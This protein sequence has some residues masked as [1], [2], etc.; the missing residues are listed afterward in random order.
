MS[1]FVLGNCIDVMARIPD[2]AIDFILTDPPY[3]VGFRD[4]QG[5]TIA[6]DKTDEWLQPAC[7]EMYRVLKKDALMVSFYGWN[8]VDRFMSAWKNAGFSVVGHLVFT[9]NYT[10]KAAYVGYRHECAY[11]LAKGRPRLPQNPLPDVLGWK[12]SGNRHHPTEKPVTSL[13]PLIES[14]THPNAIVLD[15]FAGSGSTCVAALQS[16]RRYIGIELL[17]QYHPCWLD[18]DDENLPVVLDAILNRGARFS[19]VEMYLV[20]D[21]IEHILS[22]GL[23]CDVLR[24]PDEPPRRWFD[25]GVL[26]EVVREARAEIRSM[27]DAL[28]KI[29]K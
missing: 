17:E 20:S 1:R 11:I 5:R 14:F 25:R 26:R 10:S 23:A 2:N 13:Q 16:G 4:R 24:I 29:R 8:R 18:E 22:S 21:C 7:N 6:G 3:L 12:Y 19:A 15:P 9:K 28:A 27:A